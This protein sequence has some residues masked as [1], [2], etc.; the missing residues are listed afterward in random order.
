MVADVLRETRG[1]ATNI[2]ANQALQDAFNMIDSRGNWE[3]LEQK[4]LINYRAPYTA[5]TVSCTIGT[6]AVS[7][8]LTA[9]DPT[10]KYRE[11]KFGSRRLAYPVSTVV[12]AGSL[13]LGFPLSGTTSISGGAY[14]LYQAVFPLPSDCEPGRDRKL[15]GMIGWGPK[16]DGN[17]KKLEIGRIEDRQRDEL[18]N[19]SNPLYWTDGPFD[20]SANVGTIRVWPYPKGEGEMRL[21]YYRKMPFPASGS[22]VSILPEAFERLPIIVASARLMRT[23][24]QMG[25]QQLAQDA[26][27]MLASLYDRHAV[28]PAYDGE[29]TIDLG[30]DTFGEMQF[31]FDGRLFT[32]DY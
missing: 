2:E 23:R 15:K 11:I 24:N 26:S 27:T 18:G 6:T 3:F 17:L 21:T 5:G 10:W 32:M 30:D 14:T 7:G 20:E 12:G 22:A 19:P 1:Q 25:W 13:T 28:S 31:A 8:A 9:W 16:G 4:A 29:T